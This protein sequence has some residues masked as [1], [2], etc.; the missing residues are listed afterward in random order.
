MICEYIFP[1]SRLPFVDGFLCWAGAFLFSFWLLI[2]VLCFCLAY[3]GFLFL[4]DSVWEDCRFPEMYQFLL[5]CPTYRPIIV[6][7]ILLRCCVSLV[8]AV[9]SSLLFLIYLSPFLFFLES[10]ANSLITYIQ[11]KFTYQNN[12]SKGTDDWQSLL[13]E[14]SRHR[15]KGRDLGGISLV[16]EDTNV[17][18]NK[19]GRQR[20]MWW[21]RR[22]ARNHLDMVLILVVTG[23]DE[24]NAQVEGGASRRQKAVAFL[25]MW[26]S[27]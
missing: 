12:F 21:G 18:R 27:G 2:Q 20:R 7:S 26:G 14:T 4:H 10:L 8:S 6:H 1:F 24:M 13:Q 16:S 23:G 15:V 3:S 25:G 9:T 11:S 17:C 19:D 22:G 5:G